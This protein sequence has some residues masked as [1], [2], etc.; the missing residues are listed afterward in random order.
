MG[1][2]TPL[3]AFPIVHT[4]HGLTSVSWA[5]FFIDT[6]GRICH[7]GA[8]GD[9]VVVDLDRNPSQN[10]FAVIGWNGRTTENTELRLYYT[11]KDGALF[12]RCYTKGRGPEWYDGWLN[13]QFV[14]APYSNLAANHQGS[15]R[16]RLYYQDADTDEICQLLRQGPNDR[17]SLLGRSEVGQKATKIATDPGGTVEIVYQKPDNT[18]AWIGWIP[19]KPPFPADFEYAPGASIA[20]VGSSGSQSGVRLFTVNSN[21]KLVATVYDRT[22]NTWGAGVELVEVLPRAALTACDHT[23]PSSSVQKPHGTTAFTQTTPGAIAQVGWTSAEDWDVSP[24]ST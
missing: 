19:P 18:W 16:T 15:Y 20:Y 17:F 11:N 24:R 23:P 4:S 7:S 3:G 8:L 22:S 9:G 12:E 5:I 13:G 2:T 1:P 10:Q 6:E 21:G 14:A